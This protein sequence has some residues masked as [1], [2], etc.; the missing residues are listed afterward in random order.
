MKV[1]GVPAPIAEVLPGMLAV[2]LD[3]A[4]P[5]AHSVEVSTALGS[6]LLEL[7]ALSSNA[8]TGALAQRSGVRGCVLRHGLIDP[9]VAKCIPREEAEQLQVLPMFRVH[10]ELTVAMV[11][12]QSVPI[13]DRLGN[14]T[15]CRI[16]PVLVLEENLGEYQRKYLAKGVTVDAFLA[17]IEES[18]V[19]ITETEA[20]DEGPVTD[21]DKMVDGSP[22]VNLV[23]LAIR[24]QLLLE[25][26]ELI[27]EE[28]GE[29]MGI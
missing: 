17:S 29:D 9:K 25:P 21:L 14:L 20:V 8:L 18:D 13:S 15:G 16:R 5:G 23:N 12:P 27:L 6:T 10:D 2:S 1:D 3:P 26:R 24:S 28:G 11:D 22:V 4:V 19:T 7:G